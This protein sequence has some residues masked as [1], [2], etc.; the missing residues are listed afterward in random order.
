MSK[1]ASASTSVQT[2]YVREFAGHTNHVNVISFSTDGQQLISGSYDQTARIWNIA[3]GQE[4]KVLSGHTEWVRCV[5]ISADNALVVTGSLDHT[6]KVWDAQTGKEISS[7]SD[8]SIIQA[9]AISPD[10]KLIFT[11]SEEGI[12]RLWNLESKKEV[13][14]L[15]EHMT[16][17]LTASFSPTGKLIAEATGKSIHV[18]DSQTGEKVAS[19]DTN[20]AR[21]LHLKFFG[22]S[23]LVSGS[24]DGM[25]R[26]YNIADQKEIRRFNAYNTWLQNFA[27]SSDGKY[28]FAAYDNWTSGDS[29]QIIVR[30]WLLESEKDFQD[31]HFMG[32]RMSISCVAFSPDCKYFVSGSSDKTMFLW[33]LKF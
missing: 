14:C 18:W 12:G 17:I 10:K 6:A 16:A 20:K 21:V 8:E 22:D 5:A 23:H 1:E 27:I 29:P 11:G 32:H 4:L 28:V 30:R 33:E 7:F 26:L 13:F 3:N 24:E 9:V 19:F 31:Q 25:V 2:T 15:A